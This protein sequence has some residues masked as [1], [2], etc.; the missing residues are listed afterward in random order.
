MFYSLLYLNHSVNIISKTDQLGK[1]FII[2]NRIFFKWQ[3][4]K[5]YNFCCLLWRW[6]CNNLCRLEFMF[7]SL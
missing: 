3:I 2:L 7:F 5:L 6:Y 1:K 4:Q